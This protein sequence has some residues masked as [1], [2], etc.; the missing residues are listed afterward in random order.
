MFGIFMICANFL[1]PAQ[2]SLIQSSLSSA[3]GPGVSGFVVPTQFDNCVHLS[4]SV[5]NRPSSQLL[6]ID[7]TPPTHAPAWHL[8]PVRQLVVRPGSSP[9]RPP[10]LVGCETH[11]HGGFCR[12]LVVH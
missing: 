4:L 9:Q 1:M 12:T 8:P 7:R 3:C 2:A 10:S 11:W 5:Q 6:P